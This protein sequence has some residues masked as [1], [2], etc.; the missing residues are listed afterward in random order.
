MYLFTYLLLVDKQK[1]LAQEE[2]KNELTKK[3][4]KRTEFRWEV[5]MMWKNGAQLPIPFLPVP[6]RKQANICC[7]VHASQ[8]SRPFP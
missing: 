8:V 2:K 6:P 5:T 1:K 3:R 4:I 7:Q